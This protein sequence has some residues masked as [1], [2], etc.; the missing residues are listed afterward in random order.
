MSRPAADVPIVDEPPYPLIRERLE[1]GKVVPFLGA[2]AS[3]ENRPEGAS[4][5]PGADFLPTAT[6]LAEHLRQLTNLR[7]DAA[8]EL[9]RV[10]QFYDGDEPFREGGSPWHAW[11]AGEVLRAWKM[12]ESY[13]GPHS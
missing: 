4:W 1:Q 13:K 5:E 11:S 3:L 12:V 2:G 7:A 10:A 6:E 8:T 9:S